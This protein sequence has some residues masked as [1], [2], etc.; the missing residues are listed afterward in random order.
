M[1]RFRP[2]LCGG[3]VCPGLRRGHRIGGITLRERGRRA[4][5]V[6]T[7]THQATG[8]RGKEALRTLAA[9][10]GDPDDPT[11]VNFGQNLIHETKVRTLRV[12]DTVEA[13]RV[14]LVRRNR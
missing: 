8:E 13:R 9:Y 2:T 10:W 4:R 1:N 5:C 3:R 14:C 12:G 7:T 11:D 6:V